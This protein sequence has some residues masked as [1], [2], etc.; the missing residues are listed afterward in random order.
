[1]NKLDPVVFKLG[2]AL[3]I[4]QIFEN[5]LVLLHQLI[6]EAEKIPG[7]T[8]KIGDDY[9]KKTLGKLINLLKPRIDVP[10]KALDF[11]FDAITVRNEIVHGYLTT[12]ENMVKFE[13]EDGLS[14]LAADLQGKTNEIRARDL[15][16]CKLI[17]EYLAKYGTSTETLKKLAEENR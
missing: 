6:D 1:M 15:F 17:D 8:E 3:Y 11:I 2:A 16:V 12:S 9:S 13:S 14:F 10:P 7:K 5:S 4:C